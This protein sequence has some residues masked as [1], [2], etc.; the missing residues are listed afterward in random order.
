MVTSLPYLIIL[1]SSVAK[2]RLVKP[3]EDPFPSAFG[4]VLKKIQNPCCRKLFEIPKHIRKRS[5]L[6]LYYQV[7]MIGHNNISIQDHPF[8]SHTVRK[9]FNNAFPINLSAEDIYPV[10]NCSCNKMSLGL[11]FYGISFLQNDSFL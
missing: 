6:R 7:N 3:L 8:I 9:A 1:I 10:Y 2:C 11:I 4:T 5:I